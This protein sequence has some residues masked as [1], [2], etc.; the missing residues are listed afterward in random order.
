MLSEK[1]TVSQD[2]ISAYAKK[3]IEVGGHPQGFRRWY[4]A[5]LAK[6]TTPRAQ[7]FAEAIKKNPWAKTYQELASHDLSA[8]LEESMVT[9]VEQ[10]QQEQQ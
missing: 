1:G 10:R 7:L 2:T 8:G 6:A 5:N 9:P 4:L 3:Y